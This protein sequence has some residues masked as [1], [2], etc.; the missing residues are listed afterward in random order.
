MARNIG[1]DRVYV[2]VIQCS[3]HQAKVDHIFRG[4]WVGAGMGFGPIKTGASP[5]WGIKGVWIFVFMY[6]CVIFLAE[7]PPKNWTKLKGV[8]VWMQ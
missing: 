8:A 5:S 3:N 4:C 2:F 7:S 1:G 6:V